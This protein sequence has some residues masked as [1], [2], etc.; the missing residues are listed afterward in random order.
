MLMTSLSQECSNSILQL[1][2]SLHASFHMEDL[3]P[4]VIKKKKKVEDLGPLRY[5]LGLEVHKIQGRLFINQHKYTQVLIVQA[6]L[7]KKF[8]WILPHRSM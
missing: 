3:G 7:Q 4:P 8:Q 1:E 5:F 6:C 2:T